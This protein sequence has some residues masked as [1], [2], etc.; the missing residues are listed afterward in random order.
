MLLAFLLVKVADK[1]KCDFRNLNLFLFQTRLYE[2]RLPTAGRARRL[3]RVD[4]AADG[5]HITRVQEQVRRL[6]HCQAHR[7]PSE[8]AQGERRRSS[9]LVGAV[10][11]NSWK[12]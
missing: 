2:R 3:L 5:L 6:A 12:S 8:I 7:N 1:D 10:C 11:L 4:S 9:R